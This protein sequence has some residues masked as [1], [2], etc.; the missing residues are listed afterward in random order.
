MALVLSF[1]VPLPRASKCVGCGVPD[2]GLYPR[3][4]SVTWA[5]K[6]SEEAPLSTFGVVSVAGSQVAV[7]RNL[8]LADVDVRG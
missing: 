5:A 4:F 2:Q 6:V 1:E 8:P 3:G 7:G